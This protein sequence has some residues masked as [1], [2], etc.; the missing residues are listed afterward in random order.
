MIRKMHSVIAGMLPSADLSL[1]IADVLLRIADVSRRIVNVSLRIDDVSLR[2]AV[3]LSA[4]AFF[5]PANAAAAVTFRQTCAGYGSIRVEMSTPG[6]ILLSSSP[7]GIY[8]DWSGSV[9]QISSREYEI[10]GLQEGSR[11]YLRS[12]GGGS[13]LCVV[14][15]PAGTVK[16][17]RQTGSAKD[18][19]RIRW[20]AVPYADSYTVCGMDAGGNIYDEHRTYGCSARIR[21]PGPGGKYRVRIIPEKTSG[22]FT[23]CGKTFR[24]GLQY[25]TV[26]KK[27]TGLRYKKN[28]LGSGRAF[29]AWEQSGSA[30]GY[31]LEVTDRKGGILLV[32]TGHRRPEAWLEGSALKIG[33]FY[34]LRVRG[35]VT[36]ETGR[37]AGAW[38][39]RIWFCGD[40]ENVR[41]KKRAGGIRVSWKKTEGA[42]TYYIY[43]S[44]RKPERLSEMKKAGSS[45]TDHAVFSKFKGKAIRKD[46]VYY[47]AVVPVRHSGGKTYKARPGKYYYIG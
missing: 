31:E 46:R 25:G 14:T 3:L 36:K 37:S 15:A 43:A 41:L 18:S 12:D 39:D 4:A 8:A 47:I 26:P 13:P 2:I 35:Y 24:S 1:R 9:K 16:P 42:D 21:L 45:S 10:G 33:T 28:R 40:A 32:S 22:A 27:I 23:A 17:V 6:R 30:S 34:G 29:F 11:Y 44:D 20:N 5:L 19:I 7:Y 38:S